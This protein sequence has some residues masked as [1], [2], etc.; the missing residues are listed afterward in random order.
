MFPRMTRPMILLI[1]TVASSLVLLPAQPAEACSIEPPLVVEDQAGSTVAGIPTSGLVPIHVR[2][3]LDEIE[4]GYPIVTVRDE[5]GTV[6]SGTLELTH[7]RL[8]WRADAPLQAGSTY[9]LTIEASSWEEVALSFTTAND[10]AIPLLD[11]TQSAAELRESSSPTSS[12]C[13]N[14][15]INSCDNQEYQTCWTQTAE[16]R[17]SLSVTFELDKE[18]SRFYGFEHEAPGASSSSS[19]VGGRYGDSVWAIYPDRSEDYCVLLRA[20]PLTGGEGI[21]RTVCQ[22]DTALV[23]LP[24]FVA[25]Q[26]DYAQCE[27]APVDP[28]TGEEIDTDDEESAQSGGCS[29]GGPSPPLS[30][31][32]ML[33]LVL[34]IGRS[35]SRNLSRA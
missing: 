34:A 30:G 26:P 13:C 18:A 32:W 14:V 27:D 33:L 20:T 9:A 17:P 1:A 29:A 11:L 15:G 10:D 5:L 8:V 22:S 16:Y 4:P 12:I 25:E 7:Y 23:E 31:W 35:A 3:R 24:P 19:H 21:T 6:V 28:D 2:A